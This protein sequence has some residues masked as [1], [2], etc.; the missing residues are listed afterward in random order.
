MVE[1]T[2]AP[3]GVALL[4]V[5]GILL[6]GGI[7]LVVMLLAKPKTQ[8]AGV[9]LTVL[10]LAGVLALGML[11][12]GWVQHPGVREHEMQ[13]RVE[14]EA[15]KQRAR[16]LQ[17]E[18]LTEQNA[19]LAPLTED[20]TPEPAKSA[21]LEANSEEVD[22]VEIDTGQQ[23]TEA[24]PPGEL[25]P[26]AEDKTADVPDDGG[27][28]PASAPAESDAREETAEESPAAAGPPATEDK[29]GGEAADKMEA[30]PEA[31]AD[32]ATPA[33]ARQRPA[34][35]ASPPGRVDDGY[36][37]V[38]KLDP[39]PNRRECESVLPQALDNAVTAYIRDVLR[40]P[41]R[42]ARRVRL[43]PDYIRRNIVKQEWEEPWEISLPVEVAPSNWVVLH[44]LLEFDHEVTGDI[45]N[46]CS[47]VVVAERLWITGTGLALGLALLGVLFVCLKVDQRTKGACR[48]RLGFG[49]IAVALAIAIAGLV[50]AFNL[51][52][53]VAVPA[54][55]RQV[56]IL[57]TG[58]LPIGPT[59]TAEAAST[60]ANP[61]QL[62]TDYVAWAF[63]APAVL[64]VLAVVGGIVLL[65]AHRRTR[66]ATV[67]TALV[68]GTVIVTLVVLRMA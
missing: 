18:T 7:L 27:S 29:P 61:L 60:E 23:P 59:G 6:I 21:V 9:F 54:P 46:E 35:A 55:P 38:I 2:F 52:S 67:V 40:Q 45:K 66:K 12:L 68:L 62:R 22:A 8:P 50:V 63:L 28:D 39:H 20:S 37:M 43:E 30:S 25:P 33:A 57:P 26:A 3:V 31:P 36:Q 51:W 16:E 47:R 41:L 44:V 1:T 58:S 17:P 56:E 13:A 4:G 5:M 15:I 42:V 19:V 24:S 49:A 48:T 34:W 11:F 53:P 32:D 64:L 10:G 14:Y 65:L